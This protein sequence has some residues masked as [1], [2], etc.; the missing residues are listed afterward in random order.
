V[1]LWQTGAGRRG[2]HQPFD[3]TVLYEDLLGHVAAGLA[4]PTTMVRRHPESILVPRGPCLICR[5]VVPE[6][7]PGA[8]LGYAASNSAALTSEANTLEYTSGWC[9][10]TAPEWRGRVCP[11]CRT[12]AGD[13]TSAAPG[14]DAW[15]CRVH[16][17]GRGQPPEGLLPRVVEHLLDVQDRMQRLNASM[18]LNG[19]PATPADDASWIEAL[20][21]FAGWSLPLYLADKPTSRSRSIERTP[22]P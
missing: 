6:D 11:D 12:T 7:H 20:G 13:A 3:V 4:R 5:Q 22:R 17:L 8:R 15:L 14:E 18:T 16:L 1:E 21:F 10:E 9:V 2:G 19:A